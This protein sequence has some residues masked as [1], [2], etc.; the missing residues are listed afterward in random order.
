MLKLG[1]CALCDREKKLIK[2]HIISRTLFKSVFRDY[3][4]VHY[5]N[6][7]DLDTNNKVQDAFFDTS[8]LCAECDNNFSPFEE[9]FA[10]LLKGQLDRIHAEVKLK[11]FYPP[12]Y[13]VDVYEGLNGDK[14][15]MFFLILI[16]RSSISQQPAFR[17]VKLSAMEC[18]LKKQIKS[19]FPDTFDKI[20]VL[21]FSL[22]D[23][24][25]IRKE[26]I[27]MPIKSI[28]GDEHA[29][30]FLIRGWVICYILGDSQVPFSEYRH[31]KGNQLK[32]VKLSDKQG[33]ILLDK[34]TNLSGP[35]RK[36]PV[37]Y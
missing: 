6:I 23:V 20:Y 28:F 5:V 37:K 18:W 12:K 11:L 27:S 9:Y 15:R 29:I 33:I 4:N 24:D 3:G 36:S 31:Q 26:S 13:S 22:E 14:L 30:L 17:D 10:N 7:K 16:W 21:L 35:F 34:M 19:G 2:A 25:D 8:L 32:V 1:I